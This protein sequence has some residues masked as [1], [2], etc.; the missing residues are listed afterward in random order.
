MFA[1]VAAVSPPR[2]RSRTP[3]RSPSWQGSEYGTAPYEAAATPEEPVVEAPTV[4]AA[5]PVQAAAAAAPQETPLQLP[6]LPPL[7]RPGGGPARRLRR[8]VKLLP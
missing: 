5:A 2:G 6:E 8:K 4:A 1:Q 3:G 7:Q